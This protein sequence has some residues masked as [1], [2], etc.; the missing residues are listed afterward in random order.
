LRPG[1]VCIFSY[2]N[3]F[4]E[5]SA[6]L[7]DEKRASWATSSTIKQLIIN[8]GL[9]IVSFSDLESNDDTSTWVSWI[10]VQKPGELHSVKKSQ[11]IGQVLTK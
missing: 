10:E 4:K 11:A 8:A 9:D 5:R 6:G 3:C 7:V 1:G 2:N